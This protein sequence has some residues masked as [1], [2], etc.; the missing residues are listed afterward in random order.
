MNTER[1]EVSC[2][3]RFNEVKNLAN[4]LLQALCC[5]VLS[6]AIGS[7][8]AAKSNNNFDLVFE[9]TIA[10]LELA[11][12]LLR[13]S[14]DFWAENPDVG[15]INAHLSLRQVLNG[16]PYFRSILAIGEDGILSF[17]SFNPVP[18]LGAKDLSDRGY[19]KAA[20][21]AKPKTLVFSPPVVG[22]QSG[23]TFVPLAMAVPGGTARRQRVVVLT[24][25]PETLLP[26]SNMC[27][28]CGVSLVQ[29]GK[30][31]VSSRPLSD[32]NARVIE[33]LNFDGHYGSKS[34]NVR[35]LN[36]T[37]HWKRSER[38]GIVLVYYSVEPGGE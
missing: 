35:G 23:M 33:A 38:F 5:L 6:L 25:L 15:G 37:T 3:Q 16:S 2:N 27:N 29:K 17:D 11:E 26:T 14:A 31:L 9:I 12:A 32:V 20:N 1:R 10:R 30:V 21:A 36:V 4:R 18:F 22:R 8:A 34:L 24:A 13:S 19:W 28:F 7:G